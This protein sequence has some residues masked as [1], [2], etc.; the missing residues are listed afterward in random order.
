MLTGSK[1]NFIDIDLS[2][3][4]HPGTKDIRKKYDH[5]AVKQSIRNILLSNP[6]DKPFDP[7]FGLGLN[8][9]LFEQNS[10]SDDILSNVLRRKILEMIT[11]YEP[12]AII[13][14]IIVSLPPDSNT[15][16]MTIQFS[17]Q[18]DKSVESLEF[19][20]RRAR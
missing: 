4:K 8:M 9:W 19:S 11:Q 7:G 14:E 5:E 3:L 1:Q 18:T 16:Y 15:L 12:R 6:W 13:Q 20:F 2:F 17:T 10:I